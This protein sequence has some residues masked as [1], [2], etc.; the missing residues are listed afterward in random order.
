MLICRYTVVIILQRFSLDMEE[1]RS[2]GCARLS[3]PSLTQPGPTQSFGIKSVFNV[4][5]SSLIPGF[6]NREQEPEQVSLTPA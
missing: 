5:L 4:S 1:P 2:P 6:S 3:V